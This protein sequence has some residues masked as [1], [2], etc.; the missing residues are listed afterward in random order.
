MLSYLRLSL[1]DHQR[2]ASTDDTAAIVTGAMRRLR[3][4]A[5]T[6]ATVIFSLTAIMQS[7]GAGS[8]T[9]QRIAAPMVGGMLSA[10]LVTLFL[11]PI[12]FSLMRRYTRP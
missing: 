8:E 5:M 12:I 9:M 1:Q 7:S 10:M 6:A 2:S 3:P 4:I 11:L